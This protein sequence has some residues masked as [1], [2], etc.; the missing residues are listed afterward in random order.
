MIRTSN[1]SVKKEAPEVFKLIL[2][3]MGDRKTKDPAMQIALDITVRGWTV[4]ELRDEI[5][6]QL[7]RQT[8]KN[9]RG[10]VSFITCIRS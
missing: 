3:Y 2:M 9:P 4:V 10:F 8:S 6:I 5:F 7:C 1:K